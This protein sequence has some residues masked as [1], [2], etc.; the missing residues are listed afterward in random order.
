MRYRMRSKDRMALPLMHTIN[1]HCKVWF[2]SI[3]CYCL[4]HLIQRGGWPGLRL[5]SLVPSSSG[6]TLVLTDKRRH[7]NALWIWFYTMY[8]DKRRPRG[9]LNLYWIIHILK[10][11]NALKHMKHKSFK[12]NTIARHYCLVTDSRHRSASFVWNLLG[13]VVCVAIWQHLTILTCL[14]GDKRRDG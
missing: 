9:I 10:V 8:V 7:C 2:L 12:Y 1:D 5:S 11:V 14:T 13:G 6:A 4:P 3:K